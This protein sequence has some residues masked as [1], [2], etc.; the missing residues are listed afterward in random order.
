MISRATDHFTPAAPRGSRCSQLHA[1]SSSRYRWSTWSGDRTARDLACGDC[2][3]SAQ[4]Q[5]RRETRPPRRAPQRPRAVSVRHRP[6]CVFD[7]PQTEALTSELLRFTGCR[8]EVPWQIDTSRL[9]AVSPPPA[10][11]HRES[12]VLAQSAPRPSHSRLAP[13]TLARQRQGPTRLIADVRRLSRG[14]N[15]S[16]RTFAA[17]Q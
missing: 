7:R 13:E 2:R 5:Y 16:L 11:P 12:P 15:G 14:A 10:S 9:P 3:Y 1:S 4:N 17:I 8:R 6:A